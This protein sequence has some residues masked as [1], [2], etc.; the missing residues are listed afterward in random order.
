[1]TNVTSDPISRASSRAGTDTVSRERAAAD[2]PHVAG[3]M[4]LTDGGLETTLV[5]DDGLELADFAAFPLVG[6]EAGRASLRR[7]YDSYVDIASR[8]GVGIVLET[9]TW[10]A[11]S[12]WAARQGMDLERLAELNR[13][14]VDLVLE[15]RRDRATP[16][17]PIVV[18]G[19]IGPRGDG[20]RP[21]ALM[22]ADEAERYHMLQAREFAA[23]GAD[24]IT[25]TTMTYVDEAVG[26]ARAA[27]AV[28]LPVVISFTVETD[29]RLPTG[30]TL[31]EAISAVDAATGSAP[32]YYMVNCAHPTHFADALDPHE[33]WTRRIGGIRANASTM[34]HAELDE[35]EELDAGDPD[36]LAARYATLRSAHPQIIVLGGCCG[37]S[38]RHV[39]AISRA[40]ISAA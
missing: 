6:E 31:G 26:I 18:S 36:D 11:S 7:Y 14:A 22:T 4:F 29:G 2:L 24:L 15:V 23:A 25:A 13:L 39:D 16:S 27:T 35:A 33:A 28:G 20:Y 5:F 8:D 30:A 17:T 34:S 3:G 19:C 37:T 12:D 40:C 21:D 10:R 9:A 1:M 32:A 38:H